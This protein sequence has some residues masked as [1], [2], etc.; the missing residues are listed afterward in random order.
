MITTTAYQYSTSIKLHAVGAIS[1]TQ[2]F[3]H[4]DEA[5]FTS[6]AFSDFE[7]AVESANKFVV[8]ISEK[9]NLDIGETKFS[10]L[11]EINPALSGKETISKTWDELEMAKLWIVPVDH[12]QQTSIKAVSLTQLMK[13]PGEDVYLN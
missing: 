13:I 3:P 7:S 9:I 12:A 1:T 11:S 2:L 4:A 6:K 5:L 8:D 10:V